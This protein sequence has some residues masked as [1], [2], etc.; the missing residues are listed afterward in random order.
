[1]KYYLAAKFETREIL[2]PIRKLI[3][4]KGDEVVADWLDQ[5][6]E[7][8]AALYR[9]IDGVGSAD[10]EWRACKQAEEDLANIERADV[11]VVFSN[12]ENPSPR[13]G[14]HIETGFALGLGKDVWLVGDRTS[15]FHYMQWP[16]IM[17]CFESVE[18]LTGYLSP[19][20]VEE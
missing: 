6:E 16:Q 17:K 3:E 11:V 13:G 5:E 2:Y 10:D 15:H 7:T 1:M 8:S 19:Q 14:M 12:K 20:C 9:A 18:E 4:D